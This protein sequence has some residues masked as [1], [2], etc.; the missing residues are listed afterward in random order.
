MANKKEKNAGRELVAKALENALL[1]YCHFY[2]D[3]CSDVINVDEQFLVNASSMVLDDYDRAAL[4]SAYAAVEHG[5]VSIPKA[6]FVGVVG[7]GVIDTD[8]ESHTCA[9][10]YDTGAVLL[11][12]YVPNQGGVFATAFHAKIKCPVHLGYVSNGKDYAWAF[13]EHFALEFAYYIAKPGTYGTYGDVEEED[14]EPL[15][16]SG[17]FADSEQIKEE[18]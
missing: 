15:V 4:Y 14:G 10:C 3:S 8:D 18:V 13:L 11:D 16:A 7:V 12:V 1:A 2:K 5:Y 17:P 6:G 9:M